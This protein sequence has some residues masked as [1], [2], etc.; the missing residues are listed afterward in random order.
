MLQISVWRASKYF[1]SCF[2]SLVNRDAGVIQIVVSLLTN[3]MFSGDTTS[4]NHIQFLT[5]YS[6]D[7]KSLTLSVNCIII[8]RSAAVTYIWY[9]GLNFRDLKLE[10]VL[11]GRDGH[12]NVSDFGLS[13]IGLSHQ[14]RTS[15]CCGTPQ[16]MTPEVIMMLNL[17]VIT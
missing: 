4:H 10:N 16:Y 2:V 3:F 17:N 12:C 1:D 6:R 7:M 5:I 14:D 15:S 13:K 9:V 11:V 8:L